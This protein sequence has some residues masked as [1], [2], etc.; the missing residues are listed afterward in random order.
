MLK[1]NRWSEKII[2]DRE[3]GSP[4]LWLAP[5]IALLVSGC[6]GLLIP[7]LMSKL[8]SVGGTFTENIVV[9]GP[10]FWGFIIG[11][12]LIALIMVLR[13]NELA[14]TI[15]IVS[16]ITVDLYLGLYF[17]SLLIAF[18]LLFAFYLERFP[19]I[20]P[21]ALWVWVLFLVLAIF[22][23]IRG[24]TFFDS[25]QYYVRVFL[26]AFILFWIGTLL[27]RDI[28]RI[29][30]LLKMLYIFGIIVALLT[31]IQA[32]TG[33]FLLSTSHYAA[34]LQ[35]VAGYQLGSTGISRP[36]AFLINPDPNGCFLAMMLILGLGLL[37]ESPFLMNKVL[38][39]IGSLLMVLALLFTFSTEGMLAAIAGI[40]ILL[41][42][43]GRMRYRIFFLLLLIGAALVIFIFVPTQIAL[44]L[45]HAEAPNEFQLRLGAW[46][47]GIRVI[48][49]HPL[50]GLGLGNDVYQLRS[51]PYRVP[52]QYRILDHPHDAYLEWAALGGIPILIIF[53]ILLSL[54][55][56]L[57]FHNWRLA[58]GIHGR[59]LIGVGIAVV[60]ALCVY[61]LS[62]AGWTFAPLASTGWMMLGLI[63]SPFLRMREKSNNLQED[64][65][66]TKSN[67]V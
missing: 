29:R 54:A 26:S 60:A 28:A 21:P 50:T 61:S 7:S 6:L 8:S 24:V 5:L 46:Q 10:T 36:G 45:Q 51:N 55:L 49:A 30:R 16:S 39:F 38:F 65:N 32:L 47:T 11:I 31:I 27:A 15:I 44:L 57:A 4:L 66:K 3:A 41:A 64:N 62:D 25:M 2:G 58:D 13:Q 19:W 17:V 48:Q 18:A 63:S 40:M 23:A 37:V 43:V 1:S 20:Q 12:L 52:A 42:L 67:V 59:P 34:Q 9:F 22:P 14:V 35:S 53:I 33:K 56:W